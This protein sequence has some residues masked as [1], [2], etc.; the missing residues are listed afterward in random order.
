MIKAYLLQVIFKLA[1]TLSAVDQL[2]HLYISMIVA[3]AFFFGSMSVL[4][5]R[6]DDALDRIQAVSVTFNSKLI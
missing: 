5:G 6:P 1:H 2:F 4:E 3:V